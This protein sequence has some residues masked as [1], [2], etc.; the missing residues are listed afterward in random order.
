MDIDDLALR[1]KTSPITV[2]E[3]V[4]TSARNAKATSLPAPQKRKRKAS[5]MEL[6]GRSATGQDAV[7]TPMGVPPSIF[8]ADDEVK[9]LLQH[10]R[11]STSPVPELEHRTT[12]GKSAEGTANPEIVVPPSTPPQLYADLV[13]APE[14]TTET[15]ILEDT[16]CEALIWMPN[17]TMQL[18]QTVATKGFAF[19][20]TTELGLVREHYTSIPVVVEEALP[21]LKPNAAADTKDQQSTDETSSVVRATFFPT[22]LPRKPRKH[23]GPLG[24][25]RPIGSYASFIHQATAQTRVAARW[26]NQPTPFFPSR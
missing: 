6:D 7:E 5:S 14:L 9:L 8:G 3:D 19:T 24:V 25:A 15:N 2:Q 17:T 11:E 18:P 10:L 12:A 21:M 26:K 23:D 13:P 16:G 22:P 1:P 20:A 4:G